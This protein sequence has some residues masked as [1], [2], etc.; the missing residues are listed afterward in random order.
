MP[1]TEDQFKEMREKSKKH[2]IETALKLF[3]SNWFHATSIRQ[4]AK[5]AGI[6]I[7]LMYNYF[8]SK[9][10]LLDESIKYS[11]IDI[12]AM[13]Y[14]QAN[15]MIES[16]NL[17]GLIEAIFDV[18]KSKRDTWRLFISILL[19]PEVSETG[20][21]RVEHFS[22]HI[23]Q[24]LELYFQKTGDSNPAQRAK[25]LGAL[26]HGAF[27]NFIVHGDEEVFDQVKSAIM[28]RVI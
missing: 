6:S 25:F 27:L 28:E 1:K 3:S 20:K 11:L 12:S 23:Y 16:N 15:E 14:D 26:L 17:V 9:E 21:N 5:Q 2:I 13:L 19:Q 10:E 7:G 8:Q 24:I 22:N 18:V 4:I